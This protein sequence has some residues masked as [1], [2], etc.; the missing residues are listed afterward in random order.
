MKKLFLLLIMAFVFNGVLMSADLTW[1][2]AVN[3]DWN[4]PANWDKNTVPTNEDYILI[5]FGTPDC[6]LPNN[7]TVSIAQL[8]NR[9]VII[10][11]TA[12]ITSDGVFFNEGTLTVNSKL[13][14]QN[15][16]VSNTGNIVGLSGVLL[17]DLQ[18]NTNMTD[19]PSFINSGDINLY[20]LNVSGGMFTNAG[21]VVAAKI[22]ITNNNS[23]ENMGRFFTLDTL[24]GGSDIYVNTAR[25]ENCDSML[26]GSAIVNGWGGNV[27]IF[28]TE[29]F[30]NSGFIFGGD[31]A[32][33][34]PGGKVSIF[35]NVIENSGSVESGYSSE[36][37]K[38]GKDAMASDVEFIAVTLTINPG[39]NLITGGHMYVSGKNITFSNIGVFAF[40]GDNGIEINTCASGKIDF[41]GVHMEDAFFA[42]MGNNELYSNNIIAPTEGLNYIFDPDPLQYP[43]NTTI[44][45]GKIGSGYHD[46]TGLYNTD[47]IIVKMQNQSTANKSLE[48]SVT[49][50]LGWINSITGTTSVLAPFNFDSVEI[51]YSTP[52]NIT[53]ETTDTVTMILSIEGINVDTGYAYI[54]CNPTLITGTAKNRITTKTL[55]AY[56]NPFS[57]SIKIDNRNNGKV[58]VFDIN[59]KEITTFTGNIWNGILPNGEI[60]K[61]GIYILKKTGYQPVKIVKTE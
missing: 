26:A 51:V 35:S 4:N 53:V 1:T 56:P 29:R 12:N 20:L 49:S 46:Y 8:M 47:T 23:F 58:K 33:G 37:G 3:N 17:V 6:H 55:K 9:G 34:Y 10:A 18:D 44:V 24:G 19:P 22:T 54:T 15:C 43:A 59:G 38:Y 25:F 7:E 40:L 36:K 30:N 11:D 57:K 48:F 31:G 27:D 13:L 16:G 28:A 45:K 41:S 5:P 42:V 2:G 32:D 14:I 21:Y 50:K 39:N 61:P 52:G 60:I